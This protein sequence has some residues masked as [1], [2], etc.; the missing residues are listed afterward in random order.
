MLLMLAFGFISTTFAAFM[1]SPAA[2]PINDSSFISSIRTAKVQRQ[3]KEDIGSV[4]ANVDVAGT[5]YDFSNVSF[6]F[7]NSY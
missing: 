2:E 6:I 7:D 4:G 1:S 3:E 5:G